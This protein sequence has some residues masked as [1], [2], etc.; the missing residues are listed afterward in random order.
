MPMNSG[1]DNLIVQI[2]PVLV[3][4]GVFFAL[5]FG[6]L[7]LYYGVIKPRRKRAKEAVANASSAQS[8]DS[9]PIQA[10]A[11]PPAPI[12]QVKTVYKEREPVILPRFNVKLDSGE[13]IQADTVLTILRDPADNRLLVSLDDV[14]YRSLIDRA[15]TKKKFTALMKELAQTIAEPAPPRPVTAPPAMPD[16]EPEPEPTPQM[17]LAGAVLPIMESAAPLPIAEAYSLPDEDP[18][19]EPDD[20]DL[21][22]P[23]DD[24]L[25]VPAAP[26]EAA[27]PPAQPLPPV[28]P[29]RPAVTPP[30]TPAAA[31]MAFDLPDYKALGAQDK[32]VKKG[33]LLSRGKLELTPLPELNIAAAIE[34][35]LQQKLIVSPDFIGRRIH[36]HSAPDGGV[37][38][39]VDGQFFDGVSDIA[40]PNVRNFVSATIQEWQDRQ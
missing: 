18:L 39:E 40:D 6:V 32:V 17:P 27:P 36:V 19:P 34:A 12:V 13:T 33:G 25:D 23:L 20:L 24:L 29:P 11:P 38:I 5:I 22:P 21:L 8:A 35:Y 14:A 7:V 26:A 10:A 2:V 9:A 16:S 1:A 4:Y 37:R 3:F 31:K 15:E 30:P 28:Q